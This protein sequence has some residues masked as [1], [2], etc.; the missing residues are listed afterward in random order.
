MIGHTSRWLRRSRLTAGVMVVWLGSSSCLTWQA[1]SGAPELIIGRDRPGSVRLTLE[2]GD[3]M[4]LS[5]PTVDD[6][7]VVSAVDGRAA[8]LV[9]V[10]TV[11]VRRFHIARTAGLAALIS[12]FALA[13]TAAFTDAREGSVIVPPPEPK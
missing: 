11:E 12:A 4:V 6:R 7:A 5:D 10:R 8:A 1:A 2:G 3:V 13:W 9:N